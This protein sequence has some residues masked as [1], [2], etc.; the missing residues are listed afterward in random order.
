M[1]LKIIAP[2]IL[3]EKSSLEPLQIKV[4]LILFIL[5]HITVRF[6]LYSPK[7]IKPTAK[8]NRPCHQSSHEAASSTACLNSIIHHLANF[9]RGLSLDP[10]TYDRLVVVHRHL[11][12]AS[13]PPDDDRVVDVVV[14]RLPGEEDVAGAGGGVPEAQPGAHAHATSVQ[15]ELKAVAGPVVD[16]GQE[17][18]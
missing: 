6:A 10:L 18:A 8:N 11:Y 16:R 17:E 14:E 2:A 15:G 5:S 3:V 12:L 7:K 1:L 9:T 4:K 13:P